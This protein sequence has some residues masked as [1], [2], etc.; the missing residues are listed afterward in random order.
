MVLPI[1]VSSAAWYAQAQDRSALLDQ[2]TALSPAPGAAAP[3]VALPDGNPMIVFIFK[4]CCSP[5]DQAARWIVD[6]QEEYGDRVDVLGLNVD[7]PG[8]TSRIRGWLRARN[9]EFPVLHDPTG[10]TA[11]AWGVYAPPSV[12][13]LDADANEVF[14]TMGYIQSNSRE[15]EEIV[16]NLLQ[17]SSN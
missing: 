12:I 6:F 4:A 3:E 10:Q 8:T 17:N 7:P 16:S 14:R 1:I 13:I 5:S 9:V 15:L 2:T 11:V